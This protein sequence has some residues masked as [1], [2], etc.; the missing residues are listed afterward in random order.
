MP[1]I[2]F[3]LTNQNVHSL[4]DNLVDEEHQYEMHVKKSEIST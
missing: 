1:T 2:V 4:M 3:L